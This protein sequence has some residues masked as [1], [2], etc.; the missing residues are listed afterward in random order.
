MPPAKRTHQ[1][2]ALYYPYIHIRDE[3]W[4][5]ATLLC[6]PTV[7]R[8]VPDT[9]IPEDDPAIAQYAKTPGPNGMLLQTVPARSPAA[10]DAQ[11][12]LL[13]FFGNNEVEIIAKYNRQNSPKTDDYWLHV[14]KFNKELLEYL[15]KKDLA[16]PSHDPSAYGHREWYALHPTLGSAVMT[17]LGLSIARDQHY[18]IVTPN[19]KY[20]ETLLA[21]DEA[22]LTR[23]LLNGPMYAKSTAAQARH[24]LAQL[25][26]AL[27]DVNFQAITPNI[28]A[29][30]QASPHLERFQRAIRESAVQLE[31]KR[32]PEEY[33]ETLS[34]AAEAIIDGWRE[35][36]N[37]LVN[38]FKVP[39]ITSG[40]ALTGMAI[41]AQLG[42][43]KPEALAIDA[44][45][46]VGVLT[47]N[48][49]KA[50]RAQAGPYQYLTEII[51]AQDDTLR[52]TYPLGLTAA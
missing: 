38:K 50:L 3:R 30:L 52:L 28:I 41:K 18:D 34:A 11:R 27:T 33:Q 47:Y 25:A 17:T 13:E 24:E 23:T 31:T 42:L 35:T 37:D 46:A 9:Y 40:A 39:L 22:E 6:V 51:K 1:R 43:A 26:I 19:A 49:T 20:H 21:T 15:R 48:I 36:K 8:I 4:L 45:I 2:E 10:F 16:W 7:A 12:R 5:K 44:G 29:E 14:E 32:E